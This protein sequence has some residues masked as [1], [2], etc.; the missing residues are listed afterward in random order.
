MIQLKIHSPAEVIEGKSYLVKL[1]VTNL[2]TRA[3]LPVEAMLTVGISA[4]TPWEIL[5]PAKE[6]DEYF[7][8]NE[9]RS[10]DYNM[11]IPVGT[12]GQVGFITAWVDDPTGIAIAS[13]T[14]DVVIEAAPIILYGVVTNAETGYPIEGIRVSVYGPK[15][16]TVTIGTDTDSN[17]RYEFTALT[18][19]MYIV[20]F[21]HKDYYIAQYDRTF[22][23]GTYE[24][25]TSLTPIPP[26]PTKPT[27]QIISVQFAPLTTCIIHGYE[28]PCREW[29]D[30][31]YEVKDKSC[32]VK[33]Y[34]VAAR[35][36][37]L[38]VASGSG[39]IGTHKVRVSTTRG[40]WDSSG[41]IHLE[42]DSEWTRWYY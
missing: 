20:T 27:V 33:I 31:T 15:P 18:P 21:A 29:V 19:G 39:S 9:T 2:S 3:G 42:Y 36:F 5:I 41:W 30:V 32:K 14:E 11:T 17:G 1:T 6:S 24:L 35:Q 4:T 40:T 22:A 34:V 26:P 10:F 38:G 13:A 8:P 37:I 16:S 25:N 12:G 23:E 28:T 7:G